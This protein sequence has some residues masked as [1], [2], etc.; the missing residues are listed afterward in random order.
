MRVASAGVC[1]AAAA[2][3]LLTSCS[4]TAAV[5]PAQLDSGGG[6]ASAQYPPDGDGWAQLGDSQLPDGAHQQSTSGDAA[7]RKPQ[8]H[9]RVGGDPFRGARSTEAG[10]RGKVIHLT[11]DD[12]P[13]GDNTSDLL[14]VLA[15]RGARA[16]FFVVGD[17]VRVYPE[18]VQ[19]MSADGHA[20]GNHTRNHADLRGLSDDDIRRQLLDTEESVDAAGGRIAGCMRPPYGSRDDRVV[21]VARDMGYRTVMWT[22]D[23]GD[24]YAPSRE[25]LMKRMKAATRPGVNLLLHDGGGDRT[26]TV[27]AVAQMLIRW[28]Q[29]G[30][31]FEPLPQC[32]G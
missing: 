10:S 21:R 18:L 8:R 9:R 25:E 16:T 13:W 29:K 3:A 32:L 17:M 26:E 6:D 11:F 22:A 24:W 12:G 20:V 1:A 30:Y 28:Q 7:A 15:S 2:A 14:D 23:P 19:R 31:R 4:V 27:A 5:P